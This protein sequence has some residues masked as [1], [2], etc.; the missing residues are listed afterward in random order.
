MVFKGILNDMMVQGEILS[1][2][3]IPEGHDMGDSE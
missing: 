1:P 2:H 3:T